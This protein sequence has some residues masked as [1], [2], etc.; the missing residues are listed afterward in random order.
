MKTAAFIPI[1]RNSERVTGKNFREIGGRK[2]YEHILINCVSANCFD[3]IYVDTDS[4]E[5]K[6]Y[7]K[8]TNIK[9]IDRVPALALNTANGNDMLNYQL[10]RCP[11]YNLYFQ[12]FATAPFLRSDTIRK[13]VEALQTTA[14][15]DSI[16]TVTK[17]TGWYWINGIPVNYRP[18]ILPR[19]QDA[20]FIL[21]ETTGLYGI[22]RDAL[23]QYRCRIGAKPIFYEVT[24]DEAIDLDV[25]GDFIKANRV[26]EQRNEEA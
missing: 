15:H 4:D 19:S 11:D 24:Q 22:S 7:C 18:G 2:L 8:D 10:G 20:E 23:R 26:Y 17:E 9:I 5:I 21:K 3:D 16:L 13:C 6:E 14:T 12:L 1:K 25:I